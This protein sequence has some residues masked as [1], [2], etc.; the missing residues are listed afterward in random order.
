MLGYTAK[1]LVK[2]LI[3]HQNHSG[4]DIGYIKNEKKKKYND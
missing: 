3:T 4:T 1:Y 2:Q